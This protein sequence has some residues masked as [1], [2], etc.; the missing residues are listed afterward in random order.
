[1]QR[2]PDTHVSNVGRDKSTFRDSY[3]SSLYHFHVGSIWDDSRLHAARSYTSSHDSP[4]S[5]RSSFTQSSSPASLHLYAH[6]P[7]PYVGYSSSLLVTCPY[8]RILRSWTFF[9]ISP[10]FELPLIFSFR[11]S[12]PRVVYKTELKRRAVK[13]MEIISNNQLPASH[14][15]HVRSTPQRCCQEPVS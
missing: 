10:T 1:M 13:S 9:A 6:H 5:L 2:P 14:R 12:Y 7:L 11:N 8:H 15:L 3:P 4:F